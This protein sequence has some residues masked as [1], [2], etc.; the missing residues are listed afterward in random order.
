MRAMRS[1][2]IVAAGL[3]LLLAACDPGAGGKGSD[4]IEDAGAKMDK[5]TKFQTYAMVLSDS[6]FDPAEDLKRYEDYRI[7]K[8]APDVQVTL[9]PR[10]I[11]QTLAD[12]RRARA[13]PG[14]L[15]GLD[16]AADRAVPV[17]ERLLARV[18]GLD[19]YYTTRGPLA[20]D[21]ARGRRE[22]PL[23][24]ADYK[25]AIAVW[26]PLQAAFAKL[27]DENLDHAAAF[28]QRE[29]R[30]AEYY[31]VAVVKKAGE[32]ARTIDT[33][34]AARDPARAAAAERIVGEILPLIDQGRSARATQ[35]AKDPDG[36][37]ALDNGVAE[38]AERMIGAWRDLRRAPD[39]DHHEDMM[40]PYEGIVRTAALF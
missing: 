17:L 27:R 8:A 34:E 9:I 24:I 28:Y 14:A 10:A 29:K 22:D 3:G 37:A 15:P 36:S 40:E 30:M 19:S 23:L 5:A 13:L 11:E 1:L 4:P 38:G 31:D 32:L 35:R 21:F 25:A 18:R 33:P 20:D 7:P 2:A 26:D 12:I 6:S 39:A 16:A